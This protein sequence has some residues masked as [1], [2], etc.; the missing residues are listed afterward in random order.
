[1]LGSQIWEAITASE[2]WRALGQ[3]AKGLSFLPNR[4]T[5]NERRFMRGEWVMGDRYGKSANDLITPRRGLQ[6]AH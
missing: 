4:E 3:F 1:M 6:K 2:S 5:Q